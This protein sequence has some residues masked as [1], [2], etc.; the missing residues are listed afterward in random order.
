MNRLQLLFLS[1]PTCRRRNES[2]SATANLV[3]SSLPPDHKYLVALGF[4]PSSLRHATADL[5]SHHRPNFFEEHNNRASLRFRFRASI[6][7][8]HLVLN[9][10]I[11]TY[12][13][14][15]GSSLL[16]IISLASHNSSFSISESCHHLSYLRVHCRHPLISDSVQQHFR[17]RIMAYSAKGADVTSA[18]SQLDLKITKV[19]AIDAINTIYSQ[20]LEE[21][22]RNRVLQQENAKLNDDLL[23]QA[24]SHRVALKRIETL[25]ND[26]VCAKKREATAL[27]ALQDNGSKKGV[28]KGG[29]RELSKALRTLKK[30]VREKI[31]EFKLCLSEGKYD[32]EYL[33]RY[34]WHDCPFERL[35]KLNGVQTKELDV[36]L[37]KC[38]ERLLATTHTL[39]QDII[40]MLDDFSKEQEA[41]LGSSQTEVSK[42]DVGLLKTSLP[43]DGMTTGRGPDVAGAETGQ[44]LAAKRL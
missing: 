22:S 1:N 26:V 43:A 40:K 11:K 36:L 16:A 25:E 31:K 24:I 29:S 27:R 10:R 28:S 35:K 9:K 3:T 15:G 23:S 12:S 38:R 7:A 34:R 32:A 37:S 39:G 21:K 20:M 41:S 4:C 18:S 13:A 30:S 44:L 19:E 17:H 8:S 2:F 33:M 42:V 6:S 5:H 14:S